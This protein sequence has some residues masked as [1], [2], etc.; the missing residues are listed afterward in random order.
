MAFVSIKPLTEM[1]TR[2]IVG[3]GGKHSSENLANFMCRLLEIWE[4]Q[5]TGTLMAC[6]GLNKDRF[7]FTFP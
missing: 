2:N 3:E 4:L 5:P 7:T 1:S 6:P